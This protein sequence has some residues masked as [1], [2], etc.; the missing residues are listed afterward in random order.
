M[1]KIP[2]FARVSHNLKFHAQIYVIFEQ[3]R[4]AELFREPR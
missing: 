3:I 4:Y 1:G 2:I